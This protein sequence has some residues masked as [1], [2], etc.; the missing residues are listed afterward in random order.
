MAGSRNINI[1]AGDTY[2]HELRLKDSLNAVINISTH[3]Y[4]GQL[5]LGRTASEAICSFST[6]ITDG[7]NGVVQF[8]LSSAVTSG[9][10]AG[11][12]Y[13]DFQQKNGPIV[14]TLLAGKAVVQGDVTSGS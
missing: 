12:Y 7:A 2:I 11:T 13:Y 1:Y 8:S 4:S 14:T 5:K 3:S 10:P 6:T 9:V